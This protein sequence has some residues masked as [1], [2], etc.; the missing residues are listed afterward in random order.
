GFFGIGS[1]VSIVAVSNFGVNNVVSIFLA[2][3]FVAVIALALA[4]AILKLRGI[5]F[6]ITTLAL[7]MVFSVTIRNMPTLTGGSGGKVLYNTIFNGDTTKIYWLILTM[8]LFTIL[9]SIVFEKTRVHYAISSIRNDEVVAKSSGI[10]VFKYLTVLFVITAMI[11][12][13]AG[14]IYTQQ[15]GF[16]YPET[17]FSLDFLMLPMAMALV[18]GIYSTWGSVI[19]SVVLGLV[20][21]YLRLVMPHGS[22]IIYGIIV[23]LIILFLPKGIYG[24]LESKLRTT[25]SGARK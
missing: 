19:G 12:G 9:L 7:T 4:F 1:Y 8:A 25:R 13:V 23:I 6:A 21:E 11:Q 5:Y 20:A 24:T 17:A 10:N 15:Y 3:A 18:G 22:K 14:A 2:A 16:A